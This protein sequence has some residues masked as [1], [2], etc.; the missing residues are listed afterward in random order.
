MLG[1]PAR[2]LPL[3]VGLWLAALSLSNAFILFSNIPFLRAA[4][5]LLL[6]GYLPGVAA[7]TALFP[8]ERDLDAW[9]RQGVGFALGLFAT[10]ALVWVYMLVPGRMQVPVLLGLLDAFAVAL[11]AVALWRL[12]REK[13]ATIT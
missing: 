12:A 3:R 9:E 7:L 6:A 2:R 11:A 5:I 8:P 10:S 4:G 1:M 13:E